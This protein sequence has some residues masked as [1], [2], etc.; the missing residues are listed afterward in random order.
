VRRSRTKLSRSGRRGERAAP[1]W[2]QLALS[3]LLAILP[4]SAAVADEW[5]APSAIT[6][7][8]WNADVLRDLGVILEADVPSATSARFPGSSYRS[9]SPSLLRF[10]APDGDFERF[11]SGALYHEGGVVL[12]PDDAGPSISLLGFVLRVAPAPD[13][14]QLLDAAGRHWLTLRHMQFTASVADQDLLLL[15]VSIHLAREFALRLGRESLEGAYV[16]RANLRLPALV[17]PTARSGLAGAAVCEVDLELPIDVELTAV[18]TVSQVAREAGV[19]VALGMSAQL[20]NVGE[21]TVAWGEAIAPP[22]FGAVGAH[23]FLSMAF[24]RV[25]AAGAIVQ[26]GLSG[27]KHAFRALNTGCPCPSDNFMYPGCGDIYG[28]ATNV[29]RMW[30]GPREEVSALTGDWQ[31]VGSHFDQCLALQPVGCDPVLH[32]M[33]DFRDHEGDS[34]VYHDSFQHRLEVP[35]VELSLAGATYFAEAWYLVAG[36]VASFNNLGHRAVV[37]EHAGSTWAF[38][39]ASDLVRGSVLQELPGA[40]LQTLE[41]GEGRVQLAVSTHDLG[42]GMH[43]YEYALMNLDFDRRIESL[44][45]PLTETIA[46][47]NA[48]STGL[49][50]TADPW[51]VEVEPDRIRWQAPFGE[52]LDWGALVSFRFDANAAPVA[53][54]VVLAAFE[55]GTPAAF[56]LAA[57]GPFPVPE[58]QSLLQQ[59]AALLTLLAWRRRGGRGGARSCPPRWTER[60]LAIPKRGSEIRRPRQPWP[61]ASLAVRPGRRPGGPPSAPELTQHQPLVEG[62]REP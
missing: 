14:F 30:L 45:I 40:T 27:A 58:P 32:D 50:A 57:P 37:P 17:A 60:Q 49:G 33:N 1:A 13:D 31:R 19:R 25:D 47:A 44:E 4:T 56:E 29:D 55:A 51:A 35:E 10:R 39:F 46:I 36:D 26:L 59:L 8:A 21:G 42:G 52:A 12:Q 11:E 62:G 23:P 16:G 15:N 2:L 34:P 7:L 43:H 20:E 61:S 3:S 5:T 18:E 22:S 48:G 6:S 24:Y 41:T 54:R 28:V 53:S 38:P 9:L